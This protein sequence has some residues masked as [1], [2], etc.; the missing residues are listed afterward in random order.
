[1]IRRDLLGGLV[2]VA[3]GAILLIRNLGYIPPNVEQW[4]PV[5]LI[6]IG[7]AL[8]FNWSGARAEAP[9]DIGAGTGAPSTKPAEMRVRR[10]S[11]PTGGLILIA[12]GLAFLGGNFLGGQNTPPLILI[13]L[14]LAFVIGRLWRGSSH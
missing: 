12:L 5:I 7:L 6:V 11:S 14:G 3:I 13:A 1:M 9:V 2:L 8:V 4:W 10:W